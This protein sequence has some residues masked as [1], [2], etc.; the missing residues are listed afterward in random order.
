MALGQGYTIFVRNKF[1]GCFV[2]L[3][4]WLSGRALP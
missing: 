1:Q 2:D 3:G 4:V